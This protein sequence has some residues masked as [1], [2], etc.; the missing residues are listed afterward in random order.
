M[1]SSF[2]IYSAEAELISS[3]DKARFEGFVKGREEADMKDRLAE[4][5]AKVRELE[6]ARD[7]DK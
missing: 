4:M 1:D 2:R 3:E 7:G 5:E 6:R